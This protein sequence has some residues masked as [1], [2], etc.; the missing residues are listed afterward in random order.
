MTSFLMTKIDQF[1]ASFVGQN[2]VQYRIMTLEKHEGL[3]ASETIITL[4]FHEHNARNVR[5]KPCFMIEY[6][7]VANL[8]NR[9]VPSHLQ[10]RQMRTTYPSKQLQFIKC[11]A[12]PIIAFLYY[13]ILSVILTSGLSGFG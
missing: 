9:S 11:Y 10:V 13:F 2:Q 12:A 3:Y 6:I 5:N 1:S 7:S 8:S 4:V